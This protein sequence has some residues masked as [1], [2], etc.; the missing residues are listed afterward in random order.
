VPSAFFTLTRQLHSGLSYG[1][2]QHAV[3]L[4]RRAPEFGH[5]PEGDSS[6]SPGLLYSATLGKTA[7]EFRNPNGVA[8]KLAHIH[9]RG[10][11]PWTWSSAATPLGLGGSSLLSQGSWVQQPWALGLNHFVV[12]RSP[13]EDYVAMN[14][15]LVHPESCILPFLTHPAALS[16]HADPSY[17]IPR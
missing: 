10:G 9:R 6:S 2:C 15:A 11:W 13:Q 4:G 5:F 7:S 12:V 1:G 8:A 14:T 3:V 16:L 17:R